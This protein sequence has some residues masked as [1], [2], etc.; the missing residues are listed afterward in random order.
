MGTP[1]RVAGETEYCSCFV[2]HGQRDSDLT[3][4]LCRDLGASGV[5]CWLH[6]FDSKPDLASDRQIAG[7]L[8]HAEKV[9]VL[10][11]VH[12]LVREGLRR[13]IDRLARENPEKILPL[14][15]DDTWRHPGFELRWGSRDLKGLLLDKTCIDFEDVRRYGESFEQLLRALARTG[16]PDSLPPE[17]HL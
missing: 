2:S 9:V 15:L 6:D 5:T 8:S 12:S 4:R 11:S 3:Q 13:E 14:S 10:C 7:Q 16:P 1:P 17:V